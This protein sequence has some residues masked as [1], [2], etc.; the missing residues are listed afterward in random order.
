MNDLMYENF[1]SVIL[2]K[3]VAASEYPCKNPTNIK[4]IAISYHNYLGE[5]SIDE[6][7]TDNYKNTLILTKKYL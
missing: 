5:E 3:R 7:E 2:H 1:D 6:I 4:A